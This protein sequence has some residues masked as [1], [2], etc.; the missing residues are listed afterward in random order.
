MR[1]IDANILIYAFNGS[2]PHNGACKARLDHQLN[3]IQKVGLPWGS[4][5]AFA[6]IVTN[7]RIYEYP[8][9]RKQAWEQVCTVRRQALHM[10]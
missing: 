8:A 1:L 5:L 4:L 9:S 2:S 6:R 3:G 10:V 7:P